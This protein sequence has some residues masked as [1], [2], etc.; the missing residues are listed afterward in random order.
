VHH[1]VAVDGGVRRAD[2]RRGLGNP[3]NK[4]LNNRNID[5]RLEAGLAIVMLAIIL[6]RVLSRESAGSKK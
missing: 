5:A 1:A 2:R 6:D 3:V 4:A